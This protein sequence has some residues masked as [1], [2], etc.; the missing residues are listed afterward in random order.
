MLGVSTV[1]NPYATSRKTGMI[2]RGC[3]TSFCPAEVPFLTIVL[4]IMLSD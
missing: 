3:L 4:A 1:M 2:F